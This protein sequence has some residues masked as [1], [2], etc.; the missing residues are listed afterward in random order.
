MH[1]SSS[2][3]T[4]A[5]PSTVAGRI[6]PVG[7]EATSVGTSQIFGSSLVVD[8]RRPRVDAQ[9]R[10][11]GAVHGAAHVEAAGEGDAQL[12]RQLHVGEVRV[13]LVHQRLDDAR[14]VGRRRVAVHPALGVDDRR[15][16]V[17]GAPTG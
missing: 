16:R 14:R 6:A 7:Q 9:H 15:N 12:G 5:L 11:V 4:D 3:D 17:A 10:D 13:E 8:A 2:T 1:C